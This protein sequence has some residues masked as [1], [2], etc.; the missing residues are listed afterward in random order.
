MADKEKDVAADERKE[1][2]LL[3]EESAEVA[4]VGVEYIDAESGPHFAAEVEADYME[5]DLALIGSAY[6]EDMSVT[7]CAIG[8]API[9]GDA[10]ITASAVPLMRINGDAVFKQAYASAFIASGMVDMK[11]AATPVML[12][13]EAELEQSAAALMVAGDVVVQRSAVGIVLSGKTHISEDSRVLISTKAAII[14]AIAIL[15]GFGIVALL[16]VLGAREVASKRPRLQLP[17]QLR[18][19]PEQVRHIDPHAMSSWFEARAE[20]VRR[21]A[22]EA[23]RAG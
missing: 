13:R 23:R 20:Q 2:A 8:Y 19:L 21:M 18:H 5:V 3:D 14:I 15:S 7:G 16:M 12:T 22:A 6:A 4:E 10:E 17:E 1:E 11:Q 9:E